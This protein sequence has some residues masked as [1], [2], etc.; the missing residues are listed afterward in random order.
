M[1]EMAALEK[2]DTWKIMDLLEGKKAV[3]SKWVFTLKYKL[4]RSLKRYKVRLVAQ[5]FI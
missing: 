1:E 2:N 5:G 4:D 3:G